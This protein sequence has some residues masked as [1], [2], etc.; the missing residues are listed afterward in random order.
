MANRE[1][2]EVSFSADGKDW[3]L[4]FSTNAMCEVEDAFGK[5]IVQVANDLQSDE[6]VSIKA[7]RTLFSIGVVGCEGVDQ[8]GHLMDEI[9]L[10]KAGDLIGEAFSAAF[11]VAQDEGAGKQKAAGK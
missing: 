11:P 8:A 3:V 7:M 9:G 2:G 1:K 6:G 4:R 10:S 5:G